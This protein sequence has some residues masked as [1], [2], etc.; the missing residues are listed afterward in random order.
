MKTEFHLNGSLQLILIPENDL[1]RSILA[2]FDARSRVGKRTVV[3]GVFDPP[4][5]EAAGLERLTV[6]IEA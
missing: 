4:V 2:A 1:E 6:T 3:A 5:M